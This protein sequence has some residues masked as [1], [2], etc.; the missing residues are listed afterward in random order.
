MA[1]S[2]LLSAP[3][4]WTINWRGGKIQKAMSQYPRTIWRGWNGSFISTVVAVV[5]FSGGLEA[6]HAQQGTG[7]LWT[8]SAATTDLNTPGNWKDGALPQPPGTVI[9]RTTGDALLGLTFQ[10]NLFA[11]PGQ[12]SPALRYEFLD[13]EISITNTSAPSEW[14]N[15]RPESLRIGPDSKGVKIGE[16]NGRIIHTLASNHERK[17]V[18]YVN[19]SVRGVGYFG[20][21]VE[22][23]TGA[24]HNRTLQFG[25]PGEWRHD[26]MLYQSPS[27]DGGGR[28]ENQTSILRLHKTGEGVLELGGKNYHTGGTL[29]S[30]GTLRVLQENALGVEGWVLLKSEHGY[31]YRPTEVRTLGTID[32]FGNMLVSSGTLDL[33]GDLSLNQVIV[34]AGGNLQNS[35]KGSQA[36]LESGIAGLELLE[37]GQSF[38]YDRERRVVFQGGGGEGARAI[39]FVGRGEPPLEVNG[40]T[41]AGVGTESGV[42][43]LQLLQG[44]TGYAVAPEVIVPGGELSKTVAILSGVVLEGGENTIGGEGNLVIKPAISGEGGGF[45]K[46]GSG[47][48]TINGKNT[49]TGRTTIRAGMLAINGELPESPLE[50]LDG[51]VLGGVGSITQVLIANGGRLYSPQVPGALKVSRLRME[52]GAVLNFAIRSVADHAKVEVSESV[53]LAGQLHLHIE[54]PLPDGTELFLFGK[55]EKISGGI[56]SL[57]CS[58]AYQGRSERGATSLHVGTQRMEFDAS[59]GSLKISAAPAEG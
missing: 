5:L 7:Y 26:G 30:G 41:G 21:Q 50:V 27:F 49:H 3:K 12:A 2:A 55:P 18:E 4:T 58:G 33:A 6:L 45:Q 19:E 11:P 8:G 20:R 44:G 14:L 48:L 35:K 37:R 46:V 10:Q 17:V 38:T 23:T 24:R 43:G 40:M 53:E 59:N 56:Q 28:L 32:E 25:G 22:T 47:A 9:F 42:N 31:D 1:P 15:I 52:E 13:G 54:A 34:L 36:V 39:A 57:E 51:G 29:V 16:G